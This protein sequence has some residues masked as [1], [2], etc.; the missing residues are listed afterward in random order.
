MVGFP[1]GQA[2]P[3]ADAGGG[4]MPPNWLAQ[5]IQALR[6][7]IAQNPN[8]AR[9]PASKGAGGGKRLGQQPVAGA[10]DIPVPVLRPGSVDI[11]KTTPANPYANP[12]PFGTIVT[13]QNAGQLFNQEYPN[14]GGGGGGQAQAA[15]MSREDAEQLLFTPPPA[16]FT[17]AAQPVS[18]GGTAPPPAVPM[19]TGPNQGGGRAVAS[20]GTYGGPQPTA[21][22]PPAAPSPIVGPL[23]GSPLVQPSPQ[24]PPGATFGPQFA[25]GIDPRI[26]LA[27]MG[28]GRGIGGGR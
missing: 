18:G 8:A 17:P 24:L 25:Q 26:L 13:P 27:L 6:A 28:Q 19:G 2:A 5:I 16:N 4:D 21:G 22:L 20:A 15:P 12:I 10:T 11:A 14:A 1:P 23:P 3:V 9:P 7:E